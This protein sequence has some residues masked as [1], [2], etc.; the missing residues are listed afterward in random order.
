MALQDELKTLGNA[1]SGWLSWRRGPCQS[2]AHARTGGKRAGKTH[3][4]VAVAALERTIVALA[5]GGV[6]GNGDNTRSEGNEESRYANKH[7][8]DEHERTRTRVAVIVGFRPG[9][10]ARIYTPSG[11]V[12]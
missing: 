12:V 9:A 2:D 6:T 5:G 4:I 8:E 3:I 7:D 1:G 11:A 10:R